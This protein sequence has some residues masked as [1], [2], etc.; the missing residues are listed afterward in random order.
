MRIIQ[1]DAE[2]RQ[3]RPNPA[4]LRGP[5]AGGTMNPRASAK[6]P[7]DLAFIEYL[8][9]FYY[10]LTTVTQREA[11][12]A[13][14]A[15]ALCAALRQPREKAVAALPARPRRA[16]PAGLRGHRGR[17]AMKAKPDVCAHLGE[18]V[19][20]SNTRAVLPHGLFW[21]YVADKFF[22]LTAAQREEALLAVLERSKRKRGAK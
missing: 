1:T 21:S 20:D 17:W 12:K 22:Y 9:S 18:V 14:A 15:D 2:S 6:T 19:T 5:I 3:P 13:H 8:E 7:A 11:F 16:N 10:Q 4:G